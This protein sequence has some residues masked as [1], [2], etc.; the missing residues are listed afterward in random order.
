M[1]EQQHPK[2]GPKVTLEIGAGE[3]TGASSHYPEWIKRSKASDMFI[4]SDYCK[5]GPLNPHRHPSL[6][7]HF[8]NLFKPLDLHPQEY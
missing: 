6:P 8:K 1:Q 5:H 7:E 4:S 3:I 2:R